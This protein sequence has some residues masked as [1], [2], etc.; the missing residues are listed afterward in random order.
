MQA[1]GAGVGVLLNHRQ[2]LE[3][4]RKEEG[5]RILKNERVLDL[6]GAGAVGRDNS[7]NQGM[8]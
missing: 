8:V 7:Q 4:E 1:A 2:G 6:G 3:L 5:G